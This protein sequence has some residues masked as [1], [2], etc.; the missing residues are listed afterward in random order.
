M[1][2]CLL[3][4][5]PSLPFRCLS[6]VSKAK[7]QARD[8][9]NFCEVWHEQGH[10]QS[11]HPESFQSI[12]ICRSLLLGRTSVKHLAEAALDLSSEVQKTSRHRALDGA[13]FFCNGCD[14]PTTLWIQSASSRNS[15]SN[16]NNMIKPVSSLPFGL[17]TNK[18]TAARR[19]YSPTGIGRKPQS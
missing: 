2:S 8:G 3:L 6:L 17:R 16:W 7:L 4:K 15:Q 14:E 1:L 13:P 12:S 10:H 11:T 19:A 5:Q 9:Q 18:H